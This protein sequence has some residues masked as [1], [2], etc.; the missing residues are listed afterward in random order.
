MHELHCSSFNT[1]RLL[2]YL[3]PRAPPQVSLARRTARFTNVTT[4]PTIAEDNDISTPANALKL[5]TRRLVT[6][7]KTDM[8]QFVQ[9]MRR[10]LSITDPDVEAV[11]QTKASEARPF[12]TEPMV[13]IP[14]PSPRPSYTLVSAPVPNQPNT[15][16]GTEGTSTM[17]SKSRPNPPDTSALCFQEGPSSVRGHDG[18]R[19]P[20]RQPQAGN[21][22]ET[23][24]QW[25][26]FK[27]LFGK[28]VDL[29]T[30]MNAFQ[31]M[32]NQ[33]QSIT[34]RTVANP[35]SPNA[36]ITT[37][38]NHTPIVN[39]LMI[40]RYKRKR[41]KQREKQKQT[42]VAASGITANTNANKGKMKETVHAIVVPVDTETQPKMTKAVRKAAHKAEHKAAREELQNATWDSPLGLAP[43]RLSRNSLL[44]GQWFL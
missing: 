34:S 30:T 28:D 13:R 6:E 19:D 14:T 8:P 21:V 12:A 31:T 23:L 32:L 5:P 39:N 41:D 38:H 17:D 2:S 26:D 33:G 43:V 18:S 4:M 22:V 7:D 37:A 9:M 25:E 40:S 29:N 15:E 27:G 42:D 36:S 20:P 10:S 44:G 24:R 16:T 3:T 35:S 1:R 11:N